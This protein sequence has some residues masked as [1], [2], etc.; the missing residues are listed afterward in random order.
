MIESLNKL[1][2]MAPPEAYRTGDDLVVEESQSLSESA[3]A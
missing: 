1:E 3:S 2:L